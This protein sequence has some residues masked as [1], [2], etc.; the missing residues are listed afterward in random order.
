MQPRDGETAAEIAARHGATV[1]ARTRYERCPPC[2]FSIDYAGAGS[3]KEQASDSKLKQ[4]RKAGQRAADGHRDRARVVW[5]GRKDDLTAA[6]ARGETDDQIALRYGC[7]AY[8]V[9][10]W[11]RR[12]GLAF[13]PPAEEQEARR[14]EFTPK[15]AALAREGKSDR[16]MARILGVSDKTIYGWRKK[17]GIAPGRP[18]RN[19]AK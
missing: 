19:N 10:M 15:I 18:T 2:T 7:C 11:R 16:E 13:R 17:A 3:W 9:G 4:A 1:T 14:L 12:W 6:V 5:A 8:T